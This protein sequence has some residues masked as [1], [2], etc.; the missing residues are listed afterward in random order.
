PRMQDA[1]AS[2]NCGLKQ[3]PHG[4]A[5]GTLARYMLNARLILR[6]NVLLGRLVLQNN[7]RVALF[8]CRQ[9]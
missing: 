6:H 7:Q 8:A 3:G 5:S 2:C 9:L 4:F 1:V